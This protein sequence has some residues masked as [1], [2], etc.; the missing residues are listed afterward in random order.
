MSITT[1][2]EI[3]TNYI[4]QLVQGMR[5]YR[6]PVLDVKRAPALEYDAWIAKEL[7]KMTWME[8]KNYWRGND[9]HGRIFV[10]T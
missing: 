6:I 9:G 8:V 10:S 4:G 7:E 5:D 1:V 2:I 3:Q